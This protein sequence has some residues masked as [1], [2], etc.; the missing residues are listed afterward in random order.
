[1]LVSEEFRPYDQEIYSVLKRKPPPLIAPLQKVVSTKEIRK[2]DTCLVS[3]SS[4]Q[5]SG[6]SNSQKGDHTQC[7]VHFYIHSKKDSFLSRTL[8]NL[9]SGLILSKNKKLKK[10]AQNTFSWPILP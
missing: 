7:A 10:Y 9:L 2:K 8:L 6:N 1:M 5:L 3:L 4:S